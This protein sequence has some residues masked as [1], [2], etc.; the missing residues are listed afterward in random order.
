MTAPV[1]K[2]PTQSPYSYSPP[3]DDT[4][5]II[6]WGRILL[7][8]VLIPIG[9]SAFR[10]EYGM[11]PLLSGIDLAIHEFG[12][13]LFMPFGIPILGDT[14]VILGGSLTQVALPL[15]FVWYFLYGKK[16]HRDLHA[17]MVCLWWTSMNLLSVAIYAADARAGTLMLI[18]G[19]TGE[20]DPDSHDFYN[21]FSQWGVLNRDTIYAGRL[22]AL[23]ALMFFASIVI[24]L[25]A[26][27]KTEK[28]GARS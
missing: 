2:P 21:L 4:P 27:W 7:T 24:G 26:A 16:E 22:R 18:T 25:W 1:S 11:V 8:V 5:K 3:K 10:D 28:K 13:M 14:M 23:A 9:M 15:V 19:A 12:H 17:A 6:R 20:D